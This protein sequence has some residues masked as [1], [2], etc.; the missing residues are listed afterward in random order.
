M[1]AKRTSVNA[2][3]ALA[4]AALAA[5]LVFK[6]APEPA[7]SAALLAV[8]P[9]AV[10]R[11]RLQRAGLPPLELERAASGWRLAAPIAARADPIKVERLLELARA[12]PTATFPAENLAQYELQS[13][14]AELALGA[15]TLAF[16][17]VN[18]VTSQQYVLAR[19]QVHA[20]SP[21]YFAAL[22]LTADDLI[23]RALLAPG[24]T[25]TAIELPGVSARR[26]ENGWSLDVPS[27]AA[28]RDDVNVWVDRWRHA[29]AAAA[30][31]L[32]HAAEPRAGGALVLEGGRRAPIAVER[33]EAGVL[34]TRLDERVRYRF[35]PDIGAAMLTPP[36]PER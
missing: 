1:P 3:L 10:D 15:A 34:V 5:W 16:G 31:A 20:V 27:A 26:G 9:V 17:M 29:I 19:G 21:R 6:P 23:S 4:A 33:V 22:P 24:E 2:A 18:P 36:E 14:L 32:D 13:P 12:R 8:D 11:I 7:Q 25:L 28:S 35:P 30:E